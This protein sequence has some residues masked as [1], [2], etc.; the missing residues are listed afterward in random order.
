[1]EMCQG[2]I[3]LSV[4][5]RFFTREQAPQDSGHDPK[6]LKFRGFLDIVS[7]LK[8]FLGGPVWS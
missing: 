2:R 4:R 5:K 8:R 3:M 6:L 7:D 1:M